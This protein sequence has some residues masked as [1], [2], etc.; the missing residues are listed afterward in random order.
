VHTISKRENG[1]EVPNAFRLIHDLSY[2]L[3]FVLRALGAPVNEGKTVYPA[4]RAV[5]LGIEIDTV[6][7]VMRLPAGRLVALR[8]TLDEWA[9]RVRATKVE[10]Q[11][12]IGGRCVVAHFRGGLERRGPGGVTGPCPRSPPACA[13]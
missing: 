3:R 13:Y 4:T 5:V 9:A 11:Q 2:A 6:A 10:L 12:L 1:R 7:M 8:L